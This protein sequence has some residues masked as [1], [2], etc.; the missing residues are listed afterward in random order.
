MWLKVTE[1][2]YLQN[3]S[4]RGELC[5]LSITNSKWTALRLH[6]TPGFQSQK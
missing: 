2:N 5:C 1:A 3:N 4:G 6:L